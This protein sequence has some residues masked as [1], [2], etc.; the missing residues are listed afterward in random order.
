MRDYISFWGRFC[1]LPMNQYSPLTMLAAAVGG[2]V[3]MWLW[4]IFVEAV[5]RAIDEAAY[6]E[7]QFGTN[8]KAAARWKFPFMDKF[9]K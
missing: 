9:I 1:F 2:F 4:F 3:A 5:K 6:M 8:I 7:R